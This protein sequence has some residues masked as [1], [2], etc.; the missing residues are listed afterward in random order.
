MS[1]DYPRKNTDETITELGRRF[2]EPARDRRVYA[3]L[4][5]YG[6]LRKFVP[7]IRELCKQDS[8]GEKV[9]FCDLNSSLLDYLKDKG[10][11]QKCLDLA[12]RLRNK[13]LT[14]IMEEAWHGWLSATVKANN[15]LLLAG[16]ELFYSYLDSNALALVRQYAINGKHIG[17]VLPG[18][19]RDH[20]VWAFDETPEYRRLVTGLV[21]EWTYV[22]TEGGAGGNGNSRS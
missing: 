4:G 2:R 10:M 3:V 15:G 5:T 7:K 8:F 6:Q 1:L 19:E 9:I 16:F 14:R 18:A 22:L 12:E 17:L 21:T 11:L 20:Q 13:E